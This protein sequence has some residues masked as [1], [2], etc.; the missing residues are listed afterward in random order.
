MTSKKMKWKVANNQELPYQSS[1]KKHMFLAH[2]WAKK[3]KDLSKVMTRPSPLSTSDRRP[4]LPLRAR[5]PSPQHRQSELSQKIIKIKIYH[6]NVSQK[7]IAEMH[8]RITFQNYNNYYKKL[9][10]KLSPKIIKE[11]Y[12][13]KLSQKKITESYQRSNNGDA[14]VATYVTSIYS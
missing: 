1:H 13:R 11:N 3:K 14:V 4:A 10:Q 12:H 6:I 2:T 5:K 9:S 8:C 7:I